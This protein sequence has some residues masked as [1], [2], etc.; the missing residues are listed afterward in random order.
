MTVKTKFGLKGAGQDA[1]LKLVMA[2]PSL[3]SSPTR[4]YAKLR[5]LWT[6]F[7]LSVS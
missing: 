4:S 3:P 7:W 1:Y 6:G 2:F 5:E